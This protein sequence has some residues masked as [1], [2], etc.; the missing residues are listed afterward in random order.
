MTR[1]HLRLFSL[2]TIQRGAGLALGFF[3]ATLL[4]LLVACASAPVP[5]NQELQAA[6]LAIANADQARVADYASAEL[7]SAREKLTAARAAVQQENMLLAKRLA[8]QSQV[9]A[10]LASVKADTIKAQ[11]VNDETQKSIDAI[12]QEM[13][14]N[15]GAQ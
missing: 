7:R 9:D 4:L 3:M 15:I 12:K 13:Q 6:E 5:P 11:R 10:E 8:Q 14:R 1:S 2:A